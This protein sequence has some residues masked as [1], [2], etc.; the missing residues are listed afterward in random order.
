MG[1]ETRRS[2]S[3]RPERHSGDLP[4]M[5][6]KQLQNAV[7][8]LAKLLQWRV[9]HTWLSA[10][11]TPGFPDLCLVR[12]GRLIFAELKSERGKV[13]EEQ[14]AWLDELSFTGAQTFIWYPRHWHDGTIERRLR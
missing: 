8:N 6:E 13:S 14:Q 11:S 5:T 7:V 10:R 9:Y 1:V 12:D 3:T 2:H 4:A